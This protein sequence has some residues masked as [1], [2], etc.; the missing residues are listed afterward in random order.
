MYFLLSFELSER[1]AGKPHDARSQCSE[2]WVRQNN[3]KFSNCPSEALVLATHKA[4]LI[5]GDAEE[6]VANL[7]GHPGF[8]RQPA[9]NRRQPCGVRDPILLCGAES[10]KQGECTCK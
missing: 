7:L 9:T 10:T 4:N 1:T 2:E 8:G 6:H 5:A 3:S